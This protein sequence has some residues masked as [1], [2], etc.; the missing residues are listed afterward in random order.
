MVHKEGNYNALVDVCLRREVLRVATDIDLV[1]V[2][3][4]ANV[5]HAH[6]GRERQVV[7][8][9]ETEV[10]RHAQVGDDILCSSV[11]NCAPPYRPKT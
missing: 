1:L 5:I 11:S 10:G 2:L 9:D 7:K 6:L 4:H 8:V 3:V